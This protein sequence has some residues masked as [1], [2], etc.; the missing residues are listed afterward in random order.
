VGK[1]KNLDTVALNSCIDTK[2][3]N[4]EVD[5]SSALART[6]GVDR[7][8]YMFVNGRRVRARCAGLETDHRLRDR[9][10]EDGEECGDQGCCSL[11]LPSLVGK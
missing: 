1:T 4:G 10:S 8:P 11:A 5:Q 7:T 2:A 9:V 6:L 3:T